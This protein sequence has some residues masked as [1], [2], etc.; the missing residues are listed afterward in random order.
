M[1][2][3]SEIKYLDI[4]IAQ[5]IPWAHLEKVS[6][7][8]PHNKISSALRQT[9]QRANSCNFTTY[10]RLCYI[11]HYCSHCSRSSNDFFPH[12]RH[13][14]FF[15]KRT[16]LGKRRKSEMFIHQTLLLLLFYLEKMFISPIISCKIKS[17]ISN[18]IEYL[19]YF[20]F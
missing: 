13:D 1:D 15:E 4:N 7:V 14:N 6:C 3:D 2:Q 11:A 20:I 8:G 19:N 17:T 9:N 10:S 5:N 12:S 18:Q 16:T